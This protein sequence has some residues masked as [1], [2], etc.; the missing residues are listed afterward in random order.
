M[1]PPFSFGFLGVIPKTN[2]VHKSFHEVFQ[3][4]NHDY[5]CYKLH[6]QTAFIGSLNNFPFPA[7]E[8]QLFTEMDVGVMQLCARTQEIAAAVF[9]CFRFG[10]SKLKKQREPS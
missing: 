8:K 10:K 6:R 1:P 3:R 9:R 2:V 4:T 7:A 5:L